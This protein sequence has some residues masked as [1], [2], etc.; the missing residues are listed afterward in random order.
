MATLRLRVYSWNTKGISI[1]DHAYSEEWWKTVGIMQTTQDVT[2]PN[3][4]NNIVDEL[5]IANPDL[6]FFASQK[7]LGSGDYLH[8]HALPGVMAGYKDTKK[9]QVYTLLKRTTA[10]GTGGAGRFI[11]GLGSRYG[12]RNSVYIRTELLTGVLEAEKN[13]RYEVGDNFQKHYSCGSG[14]S[15]TRDGLASYVKIGGIII[16]LVNVNLPSGHD[17]LKSIVSTDQDGV[18]DSPA[19]LKRAAFVAENSKCLDVLIT[20]LARSPLGNGKEYP[21]VLVLCG[22]LGYRSVPPP[23]TSID[24]YVKQ[25]TSERYV[26]LSMRRT[27]KDLD[28]IPAIRLYP[29]VYKS[30]ELSNALQSASI[31]HN[32]HEGTSKIYEN[33]TLYM[34]PDFPPTCMMKIKRD[35][36]NTVKLGETI[37]ISNDYDPGNMFE[38]YPSWCNRI[39]YMTLD[40]KATLQCLTYGSYNYNNMNMS[41]QAGVK[42]EF[43]VNINGY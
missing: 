10:L 26:D 28:P 31:K 18:M 40:D 2:M 4:L 36:D 24:D 12:L 7:S 30:D 8:S 5:K 16:A 37:T 25:L 35:E 11:K 3:Y 9:V 23:N 22:D 29:T 33:G 13:L 42:A 6:V 34:G 27:S 41:T 21:S 15:L 38:N 20:N 19:R 14:V 32:L 1:A 43:K 17:L 39:L